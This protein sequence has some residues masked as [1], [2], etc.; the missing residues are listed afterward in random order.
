M[1]R[2][3]SFQISGLHAGKNARSRRAGSGQRWLLKVPTTPAGWKLRVGRCSGRAMEE[4]VGPVVGH[5]NRDGRHART[6]GLC[7][8]PVAIVLTEPQFGRYPV[9]LARNSP[10]R[11][12]A[13]PQIS[14]SFANPQEAVA[15]VEAVVVLP[16]C[17]AS[18]H[19]I[20]LAT[21]FR[22]SVQTMTKPFPSW[23]RTETLKRIHAG[24]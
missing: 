10:T 23:R 12:S 17:C 2:K 5:F 13:R 16:T 19:S 9:C 14:A 24:R 6:A 4:P 18:V 20:S 22:P 1:R 11:W 3:R 7:H 8:P 15:W 21:S